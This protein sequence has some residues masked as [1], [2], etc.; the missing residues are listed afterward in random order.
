VAGAALVL[1]V[2][3]AGVLFAA[4]LAGLATGAGKSYQL[5]SGIAIT[6]IGLGTAIALAFVARG[7]V[8]VRHWSRTPALLTQLFSGIVG[9]YLVQGGRYSWGVGALVLAVAG[10]ALLLTPASFRA[11]AFGPKDR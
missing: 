5:S 9:I 11:L 1:A 3:A 10:F 6:L 4:V 8:R 7:L 2:Q